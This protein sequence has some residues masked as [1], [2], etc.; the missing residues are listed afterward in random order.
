LAFDLAEPAVRERSIATPDRLKLHVR[1]YAPIMPGFGL[2]VICLHGLTRNSRDFELVAPRIASLGRRVLVPDMRG[3]GGSDRDPDANHYAPA[4]YVG[5]VLAVL[6]ASEAPRAVFVGTSMGG[7]ITM[8]LAAM[9]PGRIAAAVLNDVGPVLEEAGLKR[10]ATYVGKQ[11]EFASWAEAALAVR[12]SQSAA[13][14]NGDAAFWEHF[15]RR[16]C[17]HRADG[18][19]VYDYDPAI[20]RPFASTAAPDMTPLFEALAKSP[21]LVVRGANSDLLS[22]EGVELM[23]LVKPD[24]PAAVVAGIGHA[25]TL[26]EPAAWDAIVDFLA[27]VP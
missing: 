25:P 11:M 4:V 26:E 16:V 24:L 9:A 21:I 5:D 17:V 10:I 3:R 12:Q 23:R 14:P 2:P 20:A 22:E 8:L 15:A 1:D 27:R 13:F 6:E 18:K 19:V 7:I